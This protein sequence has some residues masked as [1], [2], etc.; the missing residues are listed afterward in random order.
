MMIGK[1]WR[2]VIGDNETGVEWPIWKSGIFQMG[3]YSKIPDGL[4]LPQQ[5]KKNIQTLNNNI[6]IIS[7]QLFK[8]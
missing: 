5:L 3:R 2:S 8:I 4:D 1:Q 6:C 7:A